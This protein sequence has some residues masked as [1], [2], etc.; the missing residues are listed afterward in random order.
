[1]NG[2]LAFPLVKDPSS[3]YLFASRSADLA[4]SWWLLIQPKRLY[5]EISGRKAACLKLCMIHQI[6]LAPWFLTNRR[7]QRAFTS[8]HSIQQNS[9]RVTHFARSLSV[10]DWQLPKAISREPRGPQ[11]GN[12]TRAQIHWLGMFRRRRALTV[13]KSQGQKKVYIL[14]HQ[15]L[16]FYLSI[17]ASLYLYDAYTEEYCKS[18]KV[19]SIWEVHFW[20]QQTSRGNIYEDFKDLTGISNRKNLWPRPKVGHSPKG[21]VHNTT[22]STVY[23]AIWNPAFLV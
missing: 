5:C 15:N 18:I 8:F 14:H 19:S 12:F 10:C 22:V 1:M 23:Y 6:F 4:T 2:N 11:C 13:W 21:P 20:K 9:T 3:G 17:G 16:R 7:S